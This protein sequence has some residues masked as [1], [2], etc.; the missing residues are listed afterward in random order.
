MK[1]FNTKY[2]IVTDNYCAYEAQYKVWWFPFWLQCGFTNSHR[3]IED[4]KKY[5]DREHK[6]VVEY[7]NPNIEGGKNEE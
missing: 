5:I 2:R 6:K 1:L 3:T 4:A 7:Y